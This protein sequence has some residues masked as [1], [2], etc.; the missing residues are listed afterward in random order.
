MMKLKKSG[1]NQA[2]VGGK[3]NRNFLKNDRGQLECVQLFWSFLVEKSSHQVLKYVKG[4]AP[5]LQQN[6]MTQFCHT[7]T[8]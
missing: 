2:T 7:K 3:I 8:F 6:N 5:N 1:Q 4:V